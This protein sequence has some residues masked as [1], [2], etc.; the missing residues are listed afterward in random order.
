MERSSPEGCA[1]HTPWSAAVLVAA[2]TMVTF[3]PALWNDF[4]NWDDL[5]NF[6]ENPHYRGL[7]WANVRWMFTTAHLGHYIPVTWLTLGMDYVL[8]GMDP[9][10]YHLTALLLHST[11]A[12]LFYLLAYR[13]L[14]LAFESSSRHVPLS[15]SGSEGARVVHER[16]PDRGLV[17]GAVTAALLFSVHPL[18]VESVAWITER[19]DVLSGLFS[20]LAVLAYLTAVSRGA[21]GRLHP[22]WTWASVGLFA[23][24]L[25]SKSVVVGLP[26]VLLALDVYP[27]RRKGLVG[28]LAEKIPFLLVSMTVAAATLL[29]WGR[30]DLMTDLDTLGVL[31]RLAIL[32]YGLCFYLL[33]TVVPWRLSPLYE[34]HYPVRLLTATYIVPALTVAAISTAVIRLRRRWPAGLAIWTAYIAL[35]L[36]VS[37]VFQN[38][39]QIAADRFMYLPCL[40]WALLGGAGV[41]WCWRARGRGVLPDRPARLLVAL[42]GTVIVAFAALSTL[43]IRVWRDSETLWLHAIALDPTSAFNHYHLAGALSILG[44]REEARAEFAKAIALAPEGLDAKGKF[45][46]WVGGELQTSGDLDGAEQHYTAALRYAPREEMAL[47]NLGMIYV[48]RGNDRAALDMFVRLLRVAPGKD[49]ACHN[50]RV[51]SARFGLSPPELNTCPQEKAPRSNGALQAQPSPV[52]PSR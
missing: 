27:L 18:R 11:N 23:L 42:S 24:A 33:K 37:G 20:L 40:G 51:L 47:Q 41:T 39:H 15:Q 1:T 50:V 29:M 30:R 46:A 43:Q 17:L 44:K 7:G 14:A 12:V 26:L 13:L 36:P 28:L 4:V 22:G 5:G 34:L 19:R 38:G 25:L 52:A 16:E 45:Y 10:G 31:D 3:L 35:L 48:L 49:L 6:L 9:W 8:W 2:V 21:R 32:A